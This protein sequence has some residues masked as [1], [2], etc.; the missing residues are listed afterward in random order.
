MREVAVMIKKLFFFLT[1]LILSLLLIG[2]ADNGRND[3]SETSE[4]DTSDFKTT[5]DTASQTQDQTT[6]QPEM[7]KEAEYRLFVNGKEI[8][9]NQCFYYTISYY[10]PNYSLPMSMLHYDIP[11]VAVLK[12]LGAEIQWK[13]STIAKVLLYEKEYTLNIE[14]CSLS[15]NENDNLILCA[16]GGSGYFRAEEREIWMCATRITLFLDR[17][18]FDWYY[19][20]DGDCGIIE[21]KKTGGNQDGEI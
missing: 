3:P 4:P 17:I 15:T 7:Q 13:S 11:F 10:R 6:E 18:G 8:K 21:I 12:E 16:P 1:A 5:E 19:R 9:E 2:C 20:K 14:K